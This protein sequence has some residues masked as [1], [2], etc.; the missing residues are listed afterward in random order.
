MIFVATG[1]HH[2]PFD[3]LVRYAEAVAQQLPE[4]VVVQ[5]GPSQQ[6]APTCT[7]VARMTPEAFAQIL[8][9]ARVVVLHGGSSTF[10]QAEGLG[11]RPIVVPREPERAEHVD[12]HQLDFSRSLGQRAWV[13]RDL[14]ELVRRIRA[15]PGPGP[16]TDPEARSA[17]FCRRF[18]LIADALVRR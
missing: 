3:R 15:H 7:V 12:D 2:Q 11:H 8:A 5:C 13:V 10:L 6:E 18:G 17:E 14:P 16:P 4:P 9:Q 1:T